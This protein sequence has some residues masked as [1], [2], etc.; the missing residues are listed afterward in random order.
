M[1]SS[2]N[3]FCAERRKIRERNFLG[4]RRPLFKEKRSHQGFTTVDTMRKKK[5]ERMRK[6]E[7]ERERQTEKQ[8][9]RQT[10]RKV[11]DMKAVER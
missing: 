4:S 9:E 6:R 10:D 1:Q 11:K 3:N 7:K 8:T 5:R 2:M